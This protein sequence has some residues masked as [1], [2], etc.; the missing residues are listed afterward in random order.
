MKFFD[1]ALAGSY[2]IELD[3][4]HDD[5]GFFSRYFCKKSFSAK[6]LNTNWVQI[7]ISMN[8]EVGT[9]RGLHFQCSPHT[10]IKIVRCIKGSIWDVIVDLR[11]GSETFGKWFGCKL[12]EQNRTMMY[13]PIGFAH[14]FV[15]LEPNSEI[16]YHVSDFYN[17]NCEKTL[18]WNDPDVSISWPISPIIISDKDKKGK[19]LKEFSSLDI[20]FN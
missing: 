16:L 6:S 17:P 2:T 12:S 4:L 8:R 5:R 20:K 19:L 7:N 1:T 18:I 10:D 3:L 15:S 13:I 11:L 14:G 9:L